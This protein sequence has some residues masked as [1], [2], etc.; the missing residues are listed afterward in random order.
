MERTS[1]SF[2]EFVTRFLVAHAE[3]H[4]AEF[5]AAKTRGNIHHV[6]W[7]LERFP[8]VTFVHIVRAVAPS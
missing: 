1:T 6:G 3:R 8:N 4:H 5:W 7:I 2:S